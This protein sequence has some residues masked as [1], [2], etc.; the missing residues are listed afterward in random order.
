MCI[1]ASKKISPKDSNIYYENLQV[2]F[3]FYYILSY[4]L[5]NYRFLKPNMLIDFRCSKMPIFF[6]KDK[7][8]KNGHLSR[9]YSK[10]TYP[11]ISIVPKYSHILN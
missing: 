9:C 2:V 4:V 3:T 1:Y 6:K 7:A 5:S 10:S 8:D 11:G